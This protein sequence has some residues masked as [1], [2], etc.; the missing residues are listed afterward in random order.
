MDP[1]KPY[2]TML[3]SNSNKLRQVVKKDKINHPLYLFANFEPH[4]FR[5]LDKLLG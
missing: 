2:L 5:T 4:Q 1:A 3:S